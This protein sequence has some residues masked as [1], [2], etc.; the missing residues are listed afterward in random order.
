MR[1][2]D[3]WV[4]K[5]FMF[6]LSK[7]SFVIAERWSVPESCTRIRSWNCISC[8]SKLQQEQ[9]DPST[10]ADQGINVQLDRLLILDL[11]VK[12]FSKC[13]GHCHIMLIYVKFYV[14]VS[15]P[16]SLFLHYGILW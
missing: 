11:D 12:F 10:A 6:V 1:N 14:Y 7:H 9:A 13:S 2:L 16:L 3:I 15:F 4:I 8:R 5:V